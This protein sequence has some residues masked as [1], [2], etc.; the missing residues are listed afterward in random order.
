MRFYK[1][2]GINRKNKEYYRLTYTDNKERCK[3]YYVENGWNPKDLQFIEIGKEKK[4]G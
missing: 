4:K 1:V 2:V 3:K